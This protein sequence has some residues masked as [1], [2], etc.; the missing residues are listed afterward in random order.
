MARPV[1]GKLLVEQLVEV[2]ALPARV[3]EQHMG[4]RQRLDAALDDLLTLLHIY[5]GGS[6]IFSRLDA[7]NPFISD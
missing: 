7:T 6:F 2:G 1:G 3:G 4:A 5:A